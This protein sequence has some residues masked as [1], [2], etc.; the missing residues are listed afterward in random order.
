MLLKYINI[1]IREMDYKPGGKVSAIGLRCCMIA[2]LVT[3]FMWNIIKLIYFRP[4]FNENI[5]YNSDF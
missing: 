1:N 3:V 2:F 4:F 5:R